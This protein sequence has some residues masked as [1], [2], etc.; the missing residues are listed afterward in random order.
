[1]L[2]VQVSSGALGPLVTALFF[3]VVAILAVACVLGTLYAFS[4]KA[5]EFMRSIK[6]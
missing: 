2:I 5:R 3:I 4:P 6:F 1:M